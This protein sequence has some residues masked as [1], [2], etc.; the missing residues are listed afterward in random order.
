MQLIAET[1]P[2]PQGEL[3]GLH[4]EIATAGD[5]TITASLTGVTFYLK[6]NG[7]WVETLPINELLQQ[8]VDKHE[9]AAGAIPLIQERSPYGQD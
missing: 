9:E 3:M 6:K 7:R 5:Y 4:T 2:A 8:W 1:K